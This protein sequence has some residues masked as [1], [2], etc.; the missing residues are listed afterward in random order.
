MKKRVKELE[1]RVT[2][3]EMEAQERK[4]YVSIKPKINL[5]IPTISAICDKDLKLLQDIANRDYQ[6]YFESLGNM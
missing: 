2:I 1:E 4:R 6:E 3:L 5:Q